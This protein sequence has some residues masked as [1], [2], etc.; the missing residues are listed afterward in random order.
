MLKNELEA[1]DP[2]KQAGVAILISKKKIDFQSKVIRKDKKGHFILDNGKIYQDG[3]SILNIYATNA[4][5]SSFI[6]KK[7]L[8]IKAHIAPQGSQW[9]S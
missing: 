8:K 3:H 4:R 5:T 6:Q 2:K 9:R 7:L 1:N